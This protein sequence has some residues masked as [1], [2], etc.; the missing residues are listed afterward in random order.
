MSVC[1]SVCLSL[2]VS[3]FTQ[4]AQNSMLDKNTKT[5]IILPPLAELHLTK[6]EVGTRIADCAEESTWY[7]FLTCRL[8]SP[9]RGRLLTTYITCCSASVL[10]LLFANHR[11]LSY[12]EYH[13][14][15][16]QR[17]PANPG[18]P[19]TPALP[20]RLHLLPLSVRFHQTPLAPVRIMSP[21]R[22]RLP[23][24]P[25]SPAEEAGGARQPTTCNLPLHLLT[26][27]TL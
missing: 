19:V 13:S 20:S 18:S 9:G 4:D 17:L 16:N 2:S 24:A 22:S 23:V 10:Y 5:A 27:P 6:H 14:P 8:L 21:L 15:M 25:R 7:S 12:E 26:T 3:G 1:L 11:P